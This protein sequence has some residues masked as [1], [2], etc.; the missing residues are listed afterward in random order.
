[1]DEPS[2]LGGLP[3]PSVVRR[4]LPSLIWLVPA[5]A[6]AVGLWLVVH[7]WLQQGPD[8]KIRF[9]SAG[10]VEAGKTKIR[11]KEVDIG[12]V[13]AVAISDDRKGVLISAQMNKQVRDLLAADSK[14]FI[15]RPRIAGGT[16][17]GLST[18]FSGPYI[19]IE[20]GTA[21]ETSESFVGL[22][23]PPVVTNDVPGREFVLRGE[24]KGSLDF[25]TPVYYRRVEVGH[26]TRYALEPDG[27][28]VQVG[29]FVIAP[30]DRFVTAN[31]RFWHAS[32]VDL[33]LDANGL[34][35]STQSLVSIVEGGIAFQ[36][37]SDVSPVSDPA[38]AGSSFALYSNR[39]QAL[40]PPDTHRDRYV[41]HFTGS[42]RG[43]QIGAPVDL[44]G[45]VIGE[46]K[47]LGVEYEQ[48]GSLL[49]FPVVIDVYPDR[50]RSH[51]ANGQ[52]PQAG[53]AQ[54]KLILN[55]LIAHGL[56]GQLRMGNLLTGQ[57]YIALDFFPDAPKASVDWSKSPPVIPTRP[58]GPGELQD[59]LARFADKIDRL[60]VE[61][62]ATRLSD[63]LLSLDQTLKGTRKLVDH[64]DTDVA[65]QATRTLTE[66]ERTLK[67]AESVLSEDAPLQQDLQ[68]ALKAVTESAQSLGVLSDYLERHPESLLRGKVEDQK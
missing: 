5:I 48:G 17:S 19:A 61:Q 10:G 32:G 62:L 8:I 45:I 57:L 40:Q 33:S 38:P 53:G 51:S 16:V 15:V 28:G 65:A 41:M 23:T 67:S 49:Q 36:D 24:D 2:S 1:M 14:F 6:A 29:I 55:Q 54:T 25:G 44:R 34:N 3:A 26:V 9:V 30:Y 59:A 22:E 47:A 18:L 64:L 39:A 56:R 21:H 66:A 68:R 60:P 11:Y 43:L 20:P 42:L 37:L 52:F 31:S 7:A 13:Q 12:M 27:L 63:A 46:V 50:L 4:R 58:G 35:V